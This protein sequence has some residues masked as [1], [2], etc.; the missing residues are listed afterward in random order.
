LANDR[1]YCGA[2][3]HYR[4]FLFTGEASGESLE[5]DAAPN[6][7]AFR[8]INFPDA[9]NS[10][11]SGINSEGK[12]VGGYQSADGHYHGFLLSNSEVDPL[13]APSTTSQPNVRPQL[14]TPSSIHKP[15]RAR[16]GFGKLG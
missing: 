7:S 10:F 4:G 1:G 6:P 8:T 12:I 11:A 16:L 13:I 9:I 5:S 2:D 3:D 15:L 14:F